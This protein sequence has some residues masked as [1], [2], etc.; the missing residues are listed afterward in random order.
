MRV[1]VQLLIVLIILTSGF[2]IAKSIYQSK[3]NEIE[4]HQAMVEKIEALGKLE[5]SKFYIN[6]VVDLRKEV[7]LYGIKVWADKKVMLFAKGEVVGCI[8]LSKIVKDNISVSTD[9]VTIKMPAPEICYSK[10][11]HDKS[12][13][14]ELDTWTPFNSDDR[15]LMEEAFKKA[16]VQIRKTAIDQGILKL[17]QQNALQ[18]LKPIVETVSDRKLKLV[19]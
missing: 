15:L 8:D 4:F 19:Y 5:L 9:T 3:P 18:V 2:F 17:T 12:K 11:N 10:I 7:R 16:E 13:I 1:V 14:I 6:D